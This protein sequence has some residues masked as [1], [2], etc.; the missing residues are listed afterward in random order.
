M[1]YVYVTS[2]QSKNIYPHNV[3]YDFR[4]ALPKELYFPSG[5]ECALLS[6]DIYPSNDLDCNIFCDILE[7]TSFENSLLPHLSVVKS[8][9]ERFTFLHFKKVINP[10]ISSF[11]IYIRRP[12]TNEPPTESFQ[13][14]QLELLFRECSS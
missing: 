6:F 4:V 14:S 9:P 10:R 2:E 7:Q 5:Y 13:F 12:Y 1:E 8:P 3:W 11:R